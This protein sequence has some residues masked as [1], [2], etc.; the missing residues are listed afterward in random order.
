M[1][2]GI[3]FEDLVATDFNA[4]STG[5]NTYISARTDGEVILK[6]GSFSSEF[7]ALPSA[8]IWDSHPWVAGGHATV[9]AGV[10]SVDGSRFNTEPEGTLFGP[11]SS[12]EFSATFIV[13]SQH[14]GFGGGTGFCGSCGFVTGGIFCGT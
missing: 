12:M 5:A 11:G 7:T 2:A 1:P 6:P 3:C 4:G 8:A 14:I 10:L 9:S 13:R